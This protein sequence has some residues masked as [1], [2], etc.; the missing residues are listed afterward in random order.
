MVVHSQK[1]Y[2]E[3]AVA[4]GTNRLMLQNLRTALKRS[5]MH[6]EL[7]NT[8]G[9]VED[10]DCAFLQVYPVWPPHPSTCCQCVPSWRRCTISA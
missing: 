6:C 9:W 1:E 10:F 8:D 3:R 5:R 4:L 7:F 2:E